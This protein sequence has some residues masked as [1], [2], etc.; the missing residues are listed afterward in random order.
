MSHFNGDVGDE[1]ILRQRVEIMRFV[2]VAHPDVTPIGNE[3]DYLKRE[4]NRKNYVK[5]VDKRS[6][7]GS[8]IER[9]I[10][11]VIGSKID[12]RQLNNHQRSLGNGT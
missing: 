6:T 8:W 7:K 4:M 12:I 11:R 3:V 5:G 2:G 1:A 10:D 9:R